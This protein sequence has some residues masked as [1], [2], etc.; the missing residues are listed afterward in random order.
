MHPK[1]ADGLVNSVDLRS[2]LIWVGTVCQDSSS[3]KLRIITGVHV[4]LVM[5]D[6]VVI[7]IAVCHLVSF[8]TH[9]HRCSLFSE[10]RDITEVF[11]SSIYIT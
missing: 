11:C 2:S 10:A 6:E 7:I 8:Q 4:S 5:R 9:M 1:D 3:Q